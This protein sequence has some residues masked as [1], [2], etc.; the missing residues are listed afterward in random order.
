MSNYCVYKHTSP[1]GKVYIGITSRNP[2]YRWSNGNGYI[3]NRYFYSAIKKYG[4]N[5]FQHEIL[6]SDLSKE[7][8]CNIEKELIYKF[9]S[10]KREYGYNLSSGGENPAE[11]VRLSEETRKKMSESHKGWKPT[12]EQRLNYSE[13]AKK[14]GNHKTGKIGKECGKSITV[15]QID[16]N[17][18]IVGKFY[19][20]SE[21]ERLTGI[22]QN[23]I[24][25]VWYG[26]R[27]TA[28]GY[29]WIKME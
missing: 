16:L 14:R 23:H 17:G 13:A 25:D 7:D 22:N 10:N 20:A 24:R 19:G 9:Q 6:F 8:A 5:A 27:K 3:Q 11:G 1:C 29:K 2:L 18:L 4:W 28:G 21:A 26:K 15:L 12:E